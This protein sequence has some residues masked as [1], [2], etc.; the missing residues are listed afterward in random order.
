MPLY[1]VVLHCFNCCVSRFVSSRAPLAL[2]E[3]ADRND[4]VMGFNTFICSKVLFL[5]P[6]SNRYLWSVR[7][8]FFFKLQRYKKSLLQK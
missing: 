6:T 7:I 5:P 3:V 8:I 4:A 1:F 2:H